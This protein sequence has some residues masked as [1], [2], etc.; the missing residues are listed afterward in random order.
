MFDRL[1]AALPNYSVLLIEAQTDTGPPNHRFIPKSYDKHLDSAFRRA[2]QKGITVVYGAGNGGGLL[3]D[4][5]KNDRFDDNQ[6]GLID[7][8]GT[9]IPVAAASTGFRSLWI[10]Q[11]PTFTLA[12]SQSK[13]IPLYSLGENVATAGYASKNRDT[14]PDPNCVGQAQISHFVG[15]YIWPQDAC[16]PWVKR[17]E[18]EEENN[19][20]ARFSSNKKR[21][22]VR[23]YFEAAKTNKDVQKAIAAA[24]HYYTDSFGG[25]SSASAI[26]A[27]LAASVQ[28]Y[29]QQTQATAKKPGLTGLEIHAVLLASARK[30]GRDIRFCAPDMLEA[31]KIIDEGVEPSGVLRSWAAQ[32]IMRDFFDKKPITC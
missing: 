29:F 8:Y 2:I 1:I 5:T 3:D 19:A 22:D 18:N 25:T 4:P 21:H 26:V 12:S 30:S 32:D 16:Q 23:Q 9:V 27:G 10:D 24:P 17:L 7:L 15:A 14:P 6:Y 13:F 31:V 20:Y 11:Q 28:G